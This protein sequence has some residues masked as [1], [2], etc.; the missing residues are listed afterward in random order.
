MKNLVMALMTASTLLPLTAPA[1]LP[2]IIPRELLF[3]N[4]ERTSPALSPDGARMAWLAP[5]TNNVLQVWVQTVGKED[6]K[7]V[8]A[9]KRRGIRQY[10]WAEDNRTLLYLQDS[11]GDENFHV[12]GVDLPSGNVRDY[13]PVQGVR[14]MP[15]DTHPDFPDEVLLMLNLRDRGLFDVFRLSLKT[16]ALVL[17]TENPGDVGAWIADAKFRIRF[18]MITT[19]DGGTELRLREDDHAPWKSFLRVGPEEILEAVGFSADGKSVYLNSSIGRDT[20]AVILKNLD[21]GSEQLIAASEVVDAGPAL[22]HP[23]KYIVQAVA[24][25][26]GRTEWKVVDP[27]V[28]PDF[29][30]LAKVNPGDFSVVNRTA[31]DDIW[32]VAFDSDKAPGRFYKWDRAGKK[33][34][35]LF[36]TRPKLDGL[37]LAEMKPVVIPARDGLKMHSYLTV[38]VGVDAK[39]LPL[40]L[41]PHG[42]PWARDSWGFN[43]LVQWLANRGYAVLQ[44]NFRGSTGYGKAH[45]NAGNR[46]WGLKMH[47]DLID[48]VQWAIKEG[49]A[50]PQRVGI[51]GGSYGGY[52]ALAGLAFTPEVFACGVAI[53]GP[54][55]LRTLLNSIP[56]YWKPVRGMFAARLADIDNPADAELIKKASPL[57]SADQII[58]PLLIGQGANDPRV[59]QAESEQIVEAIQKHGGGV[60]YVLYPD[61]GHGFAR[62]ENRMDFNARAEE[63]LSR[64][65]QGRCEP[66]KGERIPGSTAVVREI[67]P[68]P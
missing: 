36:T 11:D 22:F 59:K 60:T 48:S 16:G 35:F 21:D 20:A 2:A 31:A 49:I 23:R 38:P 42:G 30:E 65:L 58:R 29:A 12:Y 68:R 8:T 39:N 55:N 50:D 66:L 57:F 62:P 28:A 34:T 14:A 18:A 54:S 4:P 64:Y 52:S 3:G 32:L 44:P 67:P 13:T 61:E 25:S 33:A 15:L 63:F 40:V 7:I 51:L 26:P 45:L 37:P 6:A 27:S 9:D 43:G 5:D 24:F 47:D 17:D 19:P 41:V 46:Q 1:A 10:L 53:V 56:P